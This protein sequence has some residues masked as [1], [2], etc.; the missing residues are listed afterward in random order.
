MPRDGM[1]LTQGGTLCLDLSSTVGWC[2]AATE[3]AL[4]FTGFWKLPVFG[5]EGARY[6]A[7]DE[8]L[9]DI[10]ERWQPVRLFLEAPI[11]IPALNNFRAAAQQ[12]SLRGITYAEAYRSSCSVEEIDVLS[13]RRAVLGSS[14]M[15]SD[16]AKKA[17][18]AHCRAQG[19]MVANHHAGDA[20]M[21][22]L[23]HKRGS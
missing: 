23:W 9:A 10:F 13:V 6:A 4:P 15:S 16:V 8:K 2:Y 17:V 3:T 7:F 12:F 18:V 14:S 5:G 22:W 20:A 11:P 19:I 1:L 21:L